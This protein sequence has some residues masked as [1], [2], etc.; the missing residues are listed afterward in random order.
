M[1]SEQLSELE[2]LGWGFEQSLHPEDRDRLLAT[3]QQA[4]SENQPYQTTYRLQAADDTYNSFLE[5]GTPG[6]E[7]KIIKCIFMQIKRN[8]E[9]HL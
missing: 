7:N 4:I 8:K 9:G 6:M 2:L 3:R 5:Q 1:S